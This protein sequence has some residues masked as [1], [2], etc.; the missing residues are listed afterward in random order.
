MSDVRL[1]TDGDPVDSAE[2]PAAME[3]R[4]DYSKSMTMPVFRKQLQLLGGLVGVAAL[5]AG[6]AWGEVFFVF[7]VHAVLLLYWAKVVDSQIKREHYVFTEEGL[8]HRGR[9]FTLDVFIEWQEIERCQDVA[10][11]GIAVIGGGKKI[12]LWLRRLDNDS[13]LWV[14]ETLRSRDIQVKPLWVLLRRKR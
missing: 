5:A 12:N 4:I 7:L 14:K 9:P 13:R 2:K 11:S 6:L 10:N 8:W 3:T 1:T